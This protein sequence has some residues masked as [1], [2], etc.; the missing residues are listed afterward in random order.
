MVAPGIALDGGGRRHGR[1]DE[2]LV[3]SG[4]PDHGVGASIKPGP[5][6]LLALDHGSCFGWRLALATAWGNVVATALQCLVAFA[7]LAWERW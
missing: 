4:I 7:G 6:M 5:S 1:D 3:F 2:L